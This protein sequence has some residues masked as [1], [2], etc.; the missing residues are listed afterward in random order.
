MTCQ[1]LIRSIDAFLDDELS[2]METL[3]VQ[4]HLAFCGRCRMVVESEAKLRA[5]VKTE[6]LQERAPAHL[7][8]RI[9]RA[10]EEEPTGKGRQRRAS[11]LRR[12]APLFGLLAG[13]AVAG[14][15]LTFPLQS[16]REG[17]S[18]IAEV[19]GQHLTISRGETALE[20]TSQ[21][22]SQ[23]ASWFQTRRGF[24]VKLPPL[25]RPGERL[26]GARL[27]SIANVKA[28][29][30]IYEWAGRKTSLFIFERGHSMK[31]PADLV[32]EVEGVKFSIARLQGHSM[33]WWEDQEVY[34]AVT[35]DADVDDLL[36]FG[37]I[38]V[39]GKT[40]NG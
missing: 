25:A 31:A 6:A 8:E 36:E 26:I 22:P 34:Y 10:I 16:P 19:V 7:R 23:I 14:L 32:R 38:C 13:A 12:L 27:S 5:L 18:L 4:G 20:I 35:S 29:Q 15:L 30:L 9:L 24:P 1:E 2:V 17:P 40:Q 37:L 21:D 3:K 11:S 39:K 28:A 33:V